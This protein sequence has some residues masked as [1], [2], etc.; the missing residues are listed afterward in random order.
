MDDI[1]RL[2]GT[3]YPIMMGA[4]GAI[5]GPELVAAVSEAGGLGLIATIGMDSDS[6]RERIQR[7]REMTDRPFGANLMVLNPEAPKLAEVLAEQRV[8]V[9]TTSAGSPRVLTSMLHDLGLQVLHVIP[10]PELAFKAE[11]SGVDGVVAEGGE[12]GG[13]QSPTA[14]STMCLVPEVVDAV[15]VPVVAAG[16]VFDAHGYAAALAL[17]AMGVQLGTALILTEESAAHPEYKRALID[18]GPQDT[19]V[20]PMAVGPLRV[21]KNDFLT[22]TMELD[23]EPRKQAITEAWL[24]FNE[25]CT[26]E[27]ADAGLVM[28]GQCAGAIKAI[29]PARELID[30]I[31]TGG[32]EIL[33]AR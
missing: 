11:S 30:R 33:H 17:G 6:L 8:K 13:M 31:A 24:R 26:K 1:T 25:T 10:S 21:L 27:S 23:P 32:A 4:L 18:A 9:V 12:S 16:G 5:A 20:V 7:V 15:T 29:V 28:A 14:I 3:R 2:T 22:R 19:V